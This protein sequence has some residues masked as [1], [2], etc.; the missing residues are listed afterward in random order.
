[1]AWCLAF[2]S[3]GLHCRVD[4]TATLMAK[5]DNQASAQDIDT[6]LDASQAFIVKHI[7]RDSNAEQISEALIKDD[8]GWHARIGTTEDDRKRVLTLRQ[9]CAPFG[10]LLASHTQGNHASIFIAVLCHVRPLIAR[11]M[12]MLRIAGG[13]SSIPFF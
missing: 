13:E 3:D 2:R 11:L 9:F 7:A 8:F 5:H 6:V 10:G 4:G 1:M 12:R